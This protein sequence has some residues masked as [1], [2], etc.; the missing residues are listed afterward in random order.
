MWYVLNVANSS[1][2]NNNACKNCS[3][4]I[5]CYTRFV[6]FSVGIKWSRF[7]NA[8]NHHGNGKFA[9]QLHANSFDFLFIYFTKYDSCFAMCVLLVFVFVV[10][11]DFPSCIIWNRNLSHFMPMKCVNVIIIIVYCYWCFNWNSRKFTIKVW[12][13]FLIINTI[14]KQ[15]SSTISMVAFTSKNR[16]IYQCTDRDSVAHLVLLWLASTQQ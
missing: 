13:S 6:W 12:S 11:M 4:S 15:N 2:N 9:I 5:S 16:A 7:S 1:S 3:F 10:C 8:H 14:S